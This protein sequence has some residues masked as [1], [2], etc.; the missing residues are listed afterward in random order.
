MMCQMLA[1]AV[2]QLAALGTLCTALC[3]HQHHTSVTEGTSS[4]RC[5]VDV[6]SALLLL[7]Q[8]VTCN[9]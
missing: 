5:Y 4:F 3:P 6:E 9:Y 1:R 8:L 2:R 7:G